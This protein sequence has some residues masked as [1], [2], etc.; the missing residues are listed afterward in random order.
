MCGSVICFIHACSLLTQDG[1]SEEQW[2]EAEEAVA[3]AKVEEVDLMFNEESTQRQRAVH[4]LTAGLARSTFVRGI[5]L[6][7]VPVEMI[8]SVEQTL[9]TNSGMTYVDVSSD[10][11]Y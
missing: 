7:H 8:E 2:V 6:S 4:T 11:I 9:S 10:Y 1:F 3:T 5:T